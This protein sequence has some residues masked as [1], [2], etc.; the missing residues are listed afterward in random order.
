MESSEITSFHLKYTYTRAANFLF[1][2]F[3]CP[4]T[5]RISKAR[6]FSNGKPLKNITDRQTGYGKTPA[7][8]RL[9]TESD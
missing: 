5:T 6:I 1:L 3:R 8:T 2:R 9:G 7:K 4:S